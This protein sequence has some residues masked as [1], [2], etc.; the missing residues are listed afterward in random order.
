M[1]VYFVIV[2]IVFL[3]LRDFGG[4]C[5]ISTVLLLLLLITGCLNPTPEEQLPVRVGI[6][7]AELRRWAASLALAPLA[8]GPGRL[9][10]RHC[11]RGGGLGWSPNAA[12]RGASC[13]P[14]CPVRQGPTGWLGCGHWS[15]NHPPA[16][17]MNISPLQ[18]LPRIW[19]SATGL[20]QTQQ[21][22][23]WSRA[24]QCLYVEMG[25]IQES[26]LRLH[27]RPADSK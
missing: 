17:C 6:P 4:R 18:E 27:S 21:A 3:V 9:L 23:H 16:G 20:G 11:R 2:C 12:V 26:S 5:F 14:P 22:T 7:P 8:V 10:H 15:G 24:L 25:L 19:P 13:R 1:L